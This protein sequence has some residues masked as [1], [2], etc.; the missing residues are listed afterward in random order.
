MGVISKVLALAIHALHP[1]HWW[2]AS[3]GLEQVPKPNFGNSLT[4]RQVQ[5][6][7][8]KNP[9]FRYRGKSRKT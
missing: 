5:A 8:H 7:K 4:P 6:C 9:T 1:I 2:G 3:D